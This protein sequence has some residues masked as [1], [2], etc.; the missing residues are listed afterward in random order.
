MATAHAASGSV[1]LGRWRWRTSGM[2]LFPRRRD[3]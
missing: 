1:K 2:T 3:S